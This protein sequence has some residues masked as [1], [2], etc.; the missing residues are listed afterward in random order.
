MGSEDRKKAHRRPPMMSLVS[1]LP[2]TKEANSGWVFR[3]R[4]RH[5]TNTYHLN[6]PWATSFSQTPHLLS[7]LS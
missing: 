1:I 2:Y 7:S 4:K 6:V 5:I 3:L